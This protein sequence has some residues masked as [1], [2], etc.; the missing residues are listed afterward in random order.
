MQ[1]VAALSLATVLTL[2]VLLLVRAGRPERSIPASLL[3]TAQDSSDRVHLPVTASELRQLVDKCRLKWP[4]STSHLLH[5][6]RMWTL[7]D[8][9]KDAD[10]RLSVGTLVS[11]DQVRRVFLDSARFREAYPGV[12]PWFVRGAAGLIAR[13]KQDA[14]DSSGEAHPGQFLATLAECGVSLD[15]PV[16]MSG[17]R[18]TVRDFLA[19]SSHDFTDGVASEYCAV[20]FACYCAPRRSLTNKF[21]ESILFD[22][23]MK[24]LCAI[25][26]G[27]GWCHGTHACYGVAALLRVNQTESILSQSA[28]KRGTDYL[29]RVAGLLKAAQHPDG[30]WRSDWPAGTACEAPALALA[31]WGDSIVAT[32]HHLEWLAIAPQHL[33]PR[34]RIESAMQFVVKGLREASE[35]DIVT[36]YLGWSHAARALLLWEVSCHTNAGV[37]ARADGGAL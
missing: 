11:C 8:D 25:T 7:V 26:P 6:W 21:G 3:P 35:E 4:V 36:A 33:L 32:G 17:S 34:A 30:A 27:Q 10:P 23:L 22:D 31:S 29:S 18:L 20:A 13:A 19:Q 1:R 9:S 15:E 5:F 14:T 37:I 2:V 24:T 16:A 28:V 12:P